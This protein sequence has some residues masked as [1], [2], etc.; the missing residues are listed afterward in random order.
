MLSIQSDHFDV[1]DGDFRLIVRINEAIVTARDDMRPQM[2]SSVGTIVALCRLPN[3][4]D[5]V[6]LAFDIRN[7]DRIGQMTVTSVSDVSAVAYDPDHNDIIVGNTKGE[8]SVWSN[9]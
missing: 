8:I 3:N 7:G 5:G 1:L 6:L 9:E 4:T 2:Q